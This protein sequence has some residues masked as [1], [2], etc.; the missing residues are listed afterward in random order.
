MSAVGLVGC[1]RLGA[2]LGLRILRAGSPLLVYDGD[3]SRA[4][5]LA[6]QGAEVCRSLA[7]IA[8]RCTTTVS[9]LPRPR[10]VEEVLAV[11]TEALSPRSL[12]VET[13]TIGPESARALAARAAARRIRFLDAPISRGAEAE[14]LVMWVGG[15]VDHF[16]LARPL[17]DALAERVVYCGGPGAGQTTKLVNNLIAHSLVALVGQALGL[18]MRAGVPL[19]VLRAAL[20]HGTAQNRVLDDLLP[21]SAFRGEYRPGLRLDLAA[22]D[23]DLARDLARAHGIEAP[24]FEPAR[25]LLARAEERGFSDRS[26]HA[27]LQ[28][29]EE[30]LGVEYRSLQMPD[31][32]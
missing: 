24:C 22:K 17:L 4:S 20:H 26:L 18:G 16:D 19:D 27:V 23:L 10:D 8:D 7:T 30:D 32:D 25:E 12:H 31:G 6:E 1:G 21:E 13:S 11:L 5:V 14:D 29:L 15:N 3:P 9:C 2:R 28:L